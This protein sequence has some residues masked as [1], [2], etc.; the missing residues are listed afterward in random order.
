MGMQG[1]RDKEGGLE[2]KEGRGRSQARMMMT[3][4]G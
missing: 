3:Q 1:K 4:G 2:G